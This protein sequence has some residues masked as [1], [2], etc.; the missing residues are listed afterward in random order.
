MDVCCLD[1]TGAGRVVVARHALQPAFADRVLAEIQADQPWRRGSRQPF[2]YSSPPA[3]HHVAAGN[4]AETYG[5]TYLPA[6]PFLACM[7][8]LASTVFDFE[9]RYLRDE[10][11]AD[12]GE[13]NEAQVGF[14]P[15]GRWHLRLHSDHNAQHRAMWAACP[16][17]QGGAASPRP[18]A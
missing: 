11:A 3:S 16:R 4:I 15:D 13:H 2:S 7:P 8:L 5:A 12:F 18:T 1:N 14:Y 17:A 10:S 6:L 9:L